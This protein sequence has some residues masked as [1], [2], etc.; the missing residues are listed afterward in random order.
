MPAGGTGKAYSVMYGNV[1]NR[2]RQSG[3]WATDRVKDYLNKGQAM[4][5]RSFKDWEDLQA[6]DTAT[7]VIGQD[8]YA[9]PTNFI[10]GMDVQLRDGTTR[11]LVAIK[12]I[13]YVETVRASGTGN[14]LPG[15]VA[16]QYGQ[17]FFSRTLD[18]AYTIWMYFQARPTDLSDDTDT[19][20]F[21]DCDH[22]LEEYAHAYLMR[23][24]GHDKRFK[25]G[26]QMVSSMIE[27]YSIGN[28]KH[29]VVET[30]FDTDFETAG[31]WDADIM[32]G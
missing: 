32:W 1:L 31:Y 8:N 7:G 22:I 28:G 12:P 3:T 9:L 26:L 29:G 6:E 5:Y 20:V 13:K 23:D 18:K 25:D 27:E 21:V 2:A 17:M 19:T 11:Y 15:S 4:F 10:K 14:A 16:F 24:L 30:L